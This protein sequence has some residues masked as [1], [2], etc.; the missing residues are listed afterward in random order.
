MERIVTMLMTLTL[1]CSI[2]RVVAAG[3]DAPQETQANHITLATEGFISLGYRAVAPDGSK[4]ADEYEYL[5]DAVTFGADARL[6]SLP[7]RF[8]LDVDVRNREDTFG[9]LN[10]GF[11]DLLLI[12][13]IH[14]SL[15]HNLEN[16]TLEDLDPAALDIRD[17]G[18]NYGLETTIDDVVVRFAAPRFPLHL[19]AEASRFDKEGDRQLQFLGGSG[20]LDNTIRTS[21]ARRID[22]QTRHYGIGINSHLG[23]IEAD[24][25]HREKR[26]DVNGNEVLFDNYSGAGIPPGSERPAGEFPHNG[27]PEFKGSATTLKVHT[28]YTGKLVGT[29]TL[30]KKR[31]RNEASGAEAD[32]FVGAAG[33]TWMPVTKL[34]VFLKYRRVARD[35]DNPDAVIIRDRTDPAITYGNPDVPNAVSADIDTYSGTVRYRPFRRLTLKADYRFE[36]VTREDAEAWELIPDSTTRRT[37]TLSGSARLAKGLK[38][39]FEYAH[40]EVDDPATNVEPSRLNRAKFSLAWTP[41]PRIQTLVGYTVRREERNDPVFE[42]TDAADNRDVRWERV[43]ASGTFLFSEHLALTTSYAYL[44]HQIEQDIEYHDIGGAPQIDAGVP[45]ESDAHHYAVNLHYSP[46]DRLQFNTGVSHLTSRTDFE[47]NSPDLLLPVSIASL[48][49]VKI[50][51]TRYSLS[52]DYELKKG[53][54][55]GVDYEYT[56]FNDVLDHSNDDVADGISRIVWTRLLRE[57]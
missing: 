48:A 19:Y 11:R 49:G 17:S 38:G 16:I 18:E 47:P 12:N 46:S 14:R 28:N 7:H 4:R 15:F 40:K 20:L 3:S 56:D 53:L 57:W 9:H 21:T 35:L 36:E 39:K 45:Y 43:L 27:T 33:L 24:L 42:D 1:L 30:S 5:H 25:S 31:N 51:E 2:P 52:G 6:L 50:K 34:T 41:M 10:Y 22:W 54:R 29:T 55:L 37:L 13:G 32:Y 26:F 44:R 8:H 23:P